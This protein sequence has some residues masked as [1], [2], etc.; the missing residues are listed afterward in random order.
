MME[1]GHFFYPY[2]NVMSLFQDMHAIL[3]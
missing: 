3:Y 2:N 1:Q